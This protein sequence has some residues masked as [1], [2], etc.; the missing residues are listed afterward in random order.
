MQVIYKIAKSVNT[1]DDLFLTSNGMIVNC[2]MN[3]LFKLYLEEHEYPK[4]GRREEC[5]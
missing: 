4:Y 3:F 2:N 1:E 5:P